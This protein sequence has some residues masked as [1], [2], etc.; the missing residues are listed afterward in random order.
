[1]IMSWVAGGAFAGHSIRLYLA[2]H[3]AGFAHGTFLWFL[4]FP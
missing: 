1:M 3:L 4:A 2:E